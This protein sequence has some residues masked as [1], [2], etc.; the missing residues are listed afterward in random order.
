MNDRRQPPDQ[1]DFVDDLGS[2]EPETRALNKFTGHW[3]PHYQTM[4]FS[5][6][7][8]ALVPLHPSG[9]LLRL[10]EV[11]GEQTHPIENKHSPLCIHSDSVAA[12]DGLVDSHHVFGLHVPVHD[13]P[14]VHVVQGTCSQCAHSM[15]LRPTDRQLWIV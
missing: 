6:G 12:A 7:L 3:Q 10:L 2:L 5:T 8:G 11:L 13:A 14:G 1:K 9:I 15:E 4:R